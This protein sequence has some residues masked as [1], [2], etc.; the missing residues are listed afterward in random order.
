M[1]KH[2]K[3]FYKRGW[4]FVLIGIIFMGIISSSNSSKPEKVN[5]IQKEESKSVETQASSSIENQV[6]NN[7]NEKNIDVFKVGDTVKIDN[8]NV[9]VNKV[10]T[11]NGGEFIKPK[12]G[13]EYLK[14]DITLENISNESQAVSSILMFKVVDKDGRAYNQAIIEN[15]KGQLDGE[16]GKGRKMTGEYVV[17]VPKGT[18]N[19]ELEF[20]S[21]VISKGQVV[22]KLN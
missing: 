3:V 20:D 13:N 10:S 1:S 8:F 19:L 6:N 5:S 11:S 21:S 9:R 17:E 2:K 7:E 4:F 14:I 16:L 12:K 22:I 18:K 15:Q